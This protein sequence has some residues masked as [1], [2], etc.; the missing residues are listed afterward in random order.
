ML[1]CFAENRLHH[2]ALLLTVVRFLRVYGVVVCRQLHGPPSQR[3][4]A[5]L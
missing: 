5:T 3:G 4:E 2:H 1:L